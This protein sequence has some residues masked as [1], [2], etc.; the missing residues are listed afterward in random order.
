[1][2]RNLALGPAGVTA[3]FEQIEKR[4]SELETEIQALQVAVT[5]LVTNHELA[6]LEKLTADRTAVVSYSNPMVK[7]L[8]HLDA[9]TYVVPMD[10]RGLNGMEQ[11]HGN[12]IDQFDLKDYV[13]I[14]TE[15]RQ[16]LSLRAR[17]AARAAAAKADL[18]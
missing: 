16:Y 10:L 13:Q 4:Q 9:T 15:G 14:T 6:Q 11:D 12:G 2:I 3:R 8:E 7:E 5:G 18:D 17:L 1:V